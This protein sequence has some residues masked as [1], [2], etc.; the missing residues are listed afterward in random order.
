MKSNALRYPG[1]GSQP[2][3]CDA[4]KDRFK[5]QLIDIMTTGEML[6]PNNLQASDKEYS[7]ALERGAFTICKEAG[8][9]NSA[10]SCHH[11]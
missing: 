7:G 5:Q 6:V 1:Q 11:F 10:S 2:A 9:P 8:V 3:E 4:D